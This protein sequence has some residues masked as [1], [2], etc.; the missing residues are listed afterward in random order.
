MKLTKLD[1]LYVVTHRKSPR[2]VQFYNSLPATDSD[3]YRVGVGRERQSY[4]RTDNLYY[5]PASLTELIGQ[6]P[7]AGR[8]QNASAADKLLR[9]TLDLHDGRIFGLA[10]KFLMFIASLIGASLPV[11]GLVLYIKRRKR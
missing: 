6:G 5:D 4:Y 2:A 9:M 10:G 8:Y 1:T 11:T 7:W 3:V